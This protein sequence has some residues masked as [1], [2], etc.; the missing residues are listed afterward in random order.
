MTLPGNPIE[1]ILPAAPFYLNLQVFSRKL[2][3]LT[4]YVGLAAHPTER[5]RRNTAKEESGKAHDLQS[6][7]F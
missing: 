4:S 2:V 5:L 7:E 6:G 1:Q 3:M